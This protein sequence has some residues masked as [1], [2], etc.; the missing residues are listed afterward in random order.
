MFV[1]S[2]HLSAKMLRSTFCRNNCFFFSRNYIAAPVLSA[3]LLGRRTPLPPPPN[4]GDGSGGRG[5]GG[6]IDRG[7]CE[8]AYT[9]SGHR[10]VGYSVP[11]DTSHH[12]TSPHT[13]SHHLTPHTTSHHLP[14]PHITSHHLTTPPN[15]S[16]RRAL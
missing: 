15:G 4:G 14:T 12:L 10:S 1:C 11:N 2:R 9:A 13:T 7:G 8:S 16:A 6:S 3:G 5:G